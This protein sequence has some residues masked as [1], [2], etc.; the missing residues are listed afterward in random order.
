MEIFKTKTELL[1]EL[2]RLP[3]ED[4]V[5]ERLKITPERYREVLRAAKPVLS[6]NSKHSV[7]QEEFINGITD[8]DGVGANNSR[9]PA[10]LRLALDDVVSFNS[11]SLL[12]LV[13]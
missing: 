11:P 13:N 8:V 4:E 5:V 10:L 7:T 9:Q 1:F 12:L 3:T 2:G 6:L